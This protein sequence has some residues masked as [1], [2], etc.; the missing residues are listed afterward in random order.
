MFYLKGKIINLKKEWLIIEVNN[1]G[2]KVFLPKREIVS[3]KLFQFQKIY[4]FFYYN[5]SQNNFSIFGFLEEKEFYF[6]EILVGLP[7]IGPKIAL[8]IL[9]LADI[10]TLI[11]AIK[12]QKTEFFSKIPGVGRKTAQRMIL[13]LN[14]K[15]NQIEKLA[16]KEIKEKDFE[17]I[18]VLESLG[19][20]R[21][22]IFPILKKINPDLKFEEKIKE[23]IKILSS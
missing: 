5:L 1:I 20:K 19:F 8:A 12:N 22:K 13:E 2:F 6:F 14:S 15:I 11:S 18:E 17:L 4:T 10:D 21:E 9:D 3:L 23:A 16:S 7:K